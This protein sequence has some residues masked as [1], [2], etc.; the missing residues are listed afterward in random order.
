MFFGKKRG[1]VHRILVTGA[2]DGIGLLLARDYALRGHRVLATGRRSIA[3]DEAYFKGTNI[4]YVSADQ[5]D[6]KRA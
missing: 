5:A 6:P 3:N 4:T 1:R 2:T